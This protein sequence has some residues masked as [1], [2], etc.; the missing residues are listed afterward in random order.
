ML[1]LMRRYSTLY[2]IEILGFALRGNHFHILVK[3]FPECKFT[4]EDIKK[5]HVAFYGDKR[6]LV[7]GQI[8]VLREKLSSLSEFMLEIKVGFTR[9]YN[10]RHR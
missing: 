4:N 10:K 7:D 2:L 1:D 9:F 5:R 3:M 8:P 6:L